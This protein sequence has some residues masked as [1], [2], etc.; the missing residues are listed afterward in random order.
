MQTISLER[1]NLVRTTI[2]S[3]VTLAAVTLLSMVLAHWTWEWF[4]PRREPH[5]PLPDRSGLQ[6]NA[7]Y[8]LF[9]NAQRNPDGAAPTG[10]A[11]RLLGIVAATEGQRGYA[12]MQLEAKEMI[13][14]REGDNIAPGIRL[15]KVDTDH[16]IL[17]RGGARETL[18]W[19][20]KG[21]ATPFAANPGGAER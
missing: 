12:L 9:G 13:A 5:S 20:Q 2:V 10:I 11:I 15:A 6:V 17:E 4:A 21:L 19:P 8:G 3:L 18:A 7:A 16:I 14:V 1:S